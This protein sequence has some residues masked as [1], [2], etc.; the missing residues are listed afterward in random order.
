[1]S[2]TDLLFSSFASSLGLKQVDGNYQEAGLIYLNYVKSSHA[3]PVCILRGVAFRRSN[4]RAH[5]KDKYTAVF[6]GC[7]GSS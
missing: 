4:E 1:M 3:T 7:S 5:H 2:S 6:L